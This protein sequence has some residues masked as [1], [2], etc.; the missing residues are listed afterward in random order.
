MAVYTPAFMSTFP[1]RDEFLTT[2]TASEV[3]LRLVISEEDVGVVLLVRVIDGV[4]VADG[5]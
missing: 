1:L 5:K 3:G 2:S 4:T